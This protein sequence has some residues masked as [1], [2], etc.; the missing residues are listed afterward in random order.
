MRAT[1]AEPDRGHMEALLS[2]AFG[3]PVHIA[4]WDRVAPWFVA[5]CTLTPPVPGLPPSVV[6]KWLRDDPNRCNPQQ[7]VTE[8]AGLEFLGDL[9][10]AIAPALIACDSA[11]KVLVLEDLRPRVPLYDLL[12]GAETAADATRGLVAFAR[13]LG[14]LGAATVGVGCAQAYYDRRRAL[15]SVDPRSD[16]VGPLA[17]RWEETRA[18]AAAVGVTTSTKVEAEMVGVLEALADPGAFLAFSNGDAGDNNFLVA[19]DDGRIIDFEFSGYRHALW[20]AACLHVPGPRWITIPDPVR[21]GLQDVY[22]AALTEGIPEAADDRVY[23][24]AMAAAAMTVAIERAAAR[25]AKV[26][27]RAPGDGS[28]AQ[29]IATLESGARAATQH[30]SLP[31]LSGWCRA[32]AEA[33]RSRWPDAH[34]A[35]V[36]LSGE[37]DAWVRR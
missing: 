19:G 25:I 8:R 21:T 10:L 37:P 3:L 35:L 31:H 30:R 17:D 16:R 4:R 9:G 26:D 33:L 13:A 22:R 34:E 23:G 18:A 36:R 29:M 15:G 12:D 5:R 14:H 2:Q 11:T 27:A 6:V 24:E 20:D 1:A 32:L 28:R 7:M